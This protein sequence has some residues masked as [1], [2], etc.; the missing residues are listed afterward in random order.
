MKTI[1][2]SLMPNVSRISGASTWIAAPSS[3]SSE[4][5]AV[6]TTNISHPPVRMPA[7]SDIGSAFTPGSRSSG[8]T[9]LAG[10]VLS[11]LPRR[12][13]LEYRGGEGGG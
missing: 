2:P 7:R 13:L 12:L 3:S 11:G 6:R 1:A 4:L 8:K 5:R 10:L 9:T